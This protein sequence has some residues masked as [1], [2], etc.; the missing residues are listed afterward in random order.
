MRKL[1]VKCNGKAMF[2]DPATCFMKNRRYFGW[3]F[4]PSLGVTKVDPITKKEKISGAYVEKEEPEEILEVNYQKGD[5]R[6]AF[7]EIMDA[8]RCGDLL[9]ANEETA[10]LCGLK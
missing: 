1:L 4:D 3:Q 10:K 7:K 6:G 5:L 2:Q 9:A 8:I